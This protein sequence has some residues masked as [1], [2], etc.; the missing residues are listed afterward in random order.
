MAKEELLE[1]KGVVIELLPNTLFN[2]ELESKKTIIA[3]LTGK[4]RTNNIRISLGD[5]V[6]IEISPY[7]LTRGRIKYRL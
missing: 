2:I 1:L 7:D 5:K 4:M 3:Y 6:L